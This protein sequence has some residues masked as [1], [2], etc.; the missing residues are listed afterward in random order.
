MELAIRPEGNHLLLVGAL[1]SEE[2]VRSYRHYPSLLRTW[3][4]AAEWWDFLLHRNLTDALEAWP[5]LYAYFQEEVL[6]KMHIVDHRSQPGTDGLMSP[7]PDVT[8]ERYR[9][10]KGAMFDGRYFTFKTWF[11]VG[12]FEELKYPIPRAD[13]VSEYEKPARALRRGFMLWRLKSPSKKL[14]IGPAGGTRA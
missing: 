5:Y 2:D 6:F 1:K 8:E 13:L 10:R 3:G 14:P 11:L 4:R 12:D 7:W 9:H